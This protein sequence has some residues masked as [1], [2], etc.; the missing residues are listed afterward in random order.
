MSSII[1]SHDIY[2]FNQNLAMTSCVA[3]VHTKIKHATS[4]YQ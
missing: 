4:Q 1:I 3:I 2:Q